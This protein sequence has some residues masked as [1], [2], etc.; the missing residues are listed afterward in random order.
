MTMSIINFIERAIVTDLVAH[1][2][3]KGFKF[4]RLHDGQD[5]ERPANP[6]EYLMNLDEATFYFTGPTGRTYWVM[7][8]RGNG[9][10]VV[11]DY[12][13]GLGVDEAWDGWN[14]AM[15]EFHN[16]CKVKYA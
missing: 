6:V 7:L 13:V 14:A 4:S 9:R 2:A 1:L 8:M 10:D 5:Y 3:S 15:N 11:S 16:L 12:V